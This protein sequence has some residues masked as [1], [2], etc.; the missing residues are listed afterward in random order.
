MI[1]PVA[2]D[3]ALA[4]PEDAMSPQSRRHDD[5]CLVGVG[6]S[7]LIIPYIGRFIFMNDSRHLV[8]SGIEDQDA[9]PGWP[10]EPGRRQTGQ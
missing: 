3:T 5:S 10:Q 2:I 7:R 1:R 9:R 6:K 4:E 8:P